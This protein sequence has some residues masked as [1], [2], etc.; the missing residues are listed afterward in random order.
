[1]SRRNAKIGSLEEARTALRAGNHDRLARLV[2]AIA[3]YEA[4][5]DAA[6]EVL[7]RSAVVPDPVARGNAILGFGHLARR[8]RSLNR[9][10]IEP[11]VTAGLHDPDAYVRGQ[12][13]SAADDLGQFLGWEFSATASG[14]A[15]N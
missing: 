7:L 13:Q 6:T 11:L 1:M 3:L 9:G 10:A 4:D 5:V 15:P 14:L 12:S 2:V 8:F